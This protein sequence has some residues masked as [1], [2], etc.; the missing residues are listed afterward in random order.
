MSG[1]KKK[2]ENNVKMWQNCADSP[3]TQGGS[4]TAA[5]V[6][7]QPTPFH[8]VSKEPSQSPPPPM[9]SPYTDQSATPGPACT[10]P[11]PEVQRQPSSHYDVSTGA[12]PGYR[13][14]R[15]DYTLP[16]ATPPVKTT[17]PQ[18]GVHMPGNDH[19]TGST[20]PSQSVSPSPHAY[21]GFLLST[22][23]P[24]APVEDIQDPTTM[25]MMNCPGTRS[26]AFHASEYRPPPQFHSTSA[27][28]VTFQGPAQGD[29]LPMYAA[30]A[31]T[32][33]PLSSAHIPPSVPS[34]SYGY[35]APNLASNSSLR[36]QMA[37]NHP[38]YMVPET[39]AHQ[40]TPYSFP[41]PPLHPPLSVPSS[42]PPPTTIVNQSFPPIGSFMQTHQVKNVQVFTGNADSKILVEDWVRDMQY[43]LEAIELPI[44]LRFSTVVRHLGGEARKLVLNLPP[45]DQTPEKAFEELKAEYSDAQ[46]SLDPLADFYERSQ[47]SGESACSY[48]IALESILRS[49]EEGERGGRPFPD[50]D[51]KL[52]RQFLRGLSDEEVYT[53]IAPMKP[54]LL[55]FRELQA[56]LRNLAR[57]TKKFQSQQKAKKTYAQ[58]HV[59]SEYGGNERAEK[60]RYATEISELTEIVKKLALNQEEQMAKLSHLESRVAAPHSVPPPRIQPS[61]G[62]TG[63]GVGVTCHQC[64]KRGHIARVCRA[65]FL[66]GRQPH[67]TTPAEGNTP[68][69]AQHLNA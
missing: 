11:G 10:L 22:P 36:P 16:S 62:I 41:K 43:L 53:R 30:T 7:H 61:Q 49:V 60:S 57:E 8:H 40:S 50:R 15:S 46:G 33:I 69:P 42:M 55:S 58:V 19:P 3:S 14:Q 21:P 66:E 37:P 9:L 47:K 31:I 52:T 54:R 17:V 45:Q 59:T 35:V 2:K 28:V 5:Q 65:V 34:A 39:H 12:T 32:E 20:Y 48:A 26:N 64:G 25:N 63:Q 56:E 6:V 18:V 67:S 24:Q 38:I 51:N 1:K 68:H 23:L 29:L 27:A 44:H 4:P 13:V